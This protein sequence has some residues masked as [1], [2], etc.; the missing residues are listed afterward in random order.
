[1][2]RTAIVWLA[3]LCLACSGHAAEPDKTM[4]IGVLLSGSSTQWSTFDDALVQGLR[5]RGY[6]EGRNLVIVRRYGEL[7]MSRIRSSAADLSAMQL[8]SIVTS[9][10]GT[11]LSA[12]SAAPRTPIIMAAIG[13]PV[14]AGL[15]ASLAHPG[16]NITGRS[17]WSTELTGK[18]LSLLRE[19]LPGAKRNGATIAVLMNVKEP[20]HRESIDEAERAAKAL[21][22][23]IVRIDTS[24]GLDPALEALGRAGAAGLLVFSDDPLMIEN[25]ARIADAAIRLKLPSITSPKVYAEAGGLM[26]YGMD[27]R[28]DFKLSAEYVVK[29]SK[30][31][32]P[33]D[34]P[35]QLPTKPEFTLNMKTAAALGIAIPAELRLQAHSIIE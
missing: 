7:N 13:D 10:T 24:A 31:A 14:G 34:L 28:D 4:R 12:A 2:T 16:G 33:A 18:R 22:L 19:A 35:I 17:S 30:G 32:K 8:D 25:R 23:T 20:S 3:G 9:C 29:V 11:T 27:T 5:E 26:S 21:N 6:V 15:V 1:M